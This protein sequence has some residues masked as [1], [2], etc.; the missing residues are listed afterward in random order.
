MNVGFTV[1]RYG[2]FIMLM[3]GESIFSLLIVFLPEQDLRFYVAFLG[4]IL[5]VTLLQY[6]HFRSQPHDAESHAMRRSKNAGVLWALFMQAYAFSLVTLG[7]TFTIFLTFFLMSSPD[8]RLAGA[9]FLDP[10]QHLSRAGHLFSASLTTVFVCLDA[11]NILHIGVQ[12]SSARCHCSAGKGKNVKGILIVAAKGVLTITTATLS[13]WLH[14]PEEFACAGVVCV[15]MQL[16]LRRL[17]VSYLR[18]SRSNEI[19]VNHWPNTTEARAFGS[20]DAIP[21]DQ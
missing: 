8:R 5:S 10:N 9:S 1:H 3:L 17:G 15:M 21:H 19:Q 11:M 2:E 12:E 7:A 20:D 13:Q 18:R 16:L 4:G 6:L 14:Q